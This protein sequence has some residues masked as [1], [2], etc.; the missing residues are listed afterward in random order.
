MMNNQKTDLDYVNYGREGHKKK[1]ACLT[2]NEPLSKIQE[3]KLK[4]TLIIHTGEGLNCYWV[5]SIPIEV[6]SYGTE[7]I[8]APNK[9]LS[10]ELGSDAGTQYQASEQYTPRDI[11]AD[12]PELDEDEY[13]FWED[14]AD[15]KEMEGQANSEEFGDR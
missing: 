15:K 14:Q 7:P 2:Y 13:T 3:F 10:S 6:S 11:A 5:S 1:P 12:A 9:S 8:E 4:P